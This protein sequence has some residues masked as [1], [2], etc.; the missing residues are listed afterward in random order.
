MVMFG[1]AG[2]KHGSS[3]GNT[4]S[5]K[6]A[7][8]AVEASSLRTIQSPHFLRFLVGLPQQCLPSNTDIADEGQIIRNRVNLLTR[9]HLN[10]FGY[11]D[12]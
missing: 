11:F 8:E 6:R 2:K 5:L 10:I 9:F 4:I 3:S 1:I 12:E 7:R